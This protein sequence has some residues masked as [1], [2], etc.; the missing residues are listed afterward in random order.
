[1]PTN[2]RLYSF[3]PFT[4]D[5]SAR[6]LSIKDRPVALG[7]RSFEILVALLERRG[8]V[9]SKQDLLA[10]AWPGVH[11]EEHNLKVH[12]STLRRA[13]GEDGQGLLINIPGRGYSFVGTVEQHERAPRT[14]D[15]EFEGGVAAGEPPSVSEARVQIAPTVRIGIIHSLTG[16]MAQSEGPISE[17]T[18]L[19][20]E[21]INQAGGVLGRPIEPLVVDCESDE[22]CFSARAEE[23][24]TRE[25][26]SALFGCLT[27][28][29][30][31]QVKTVVERHD[32]LLIYP[33]QYEG[34]EQ[35]PNIFYLGAAPNQQLLPAAQWTFAF[36]RRRR[37]FLI[38]WDSIYSRASNAIL[39]DEIGALGGTVVGEEYIHVAGIEI[40]S[41][42]QKIA[43]ADADIILNSVVGDLNAPFCRALRGKGI[44]APDVP[45]VY[46][47]ISE[48]ELRGIPRSDAIGDY[49]VFSYFQSVDRPENRAFVAAFK[50]RYGN[51]RVTSD[52]M[53]SSYFG[54]YLWAQATKEAGGS[55]DISA[56]RQALRGQSFNA[57]G[58]RVT[59]D[60]ENQHTWKTVRI[61]EITNGGD[62]SVVWSS[63]KPIRPQ[64]YPASRS[65]AEWNEF[66][67]SAFGHWKGHWSRPSPL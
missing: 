45:M 46:L 10:R 22:T 63:E 34:L 12:V 1:M 39:R 7:S 33:M 55:S 14:A 15:G 35:S 64:P 65:V 56:V 9:V 30:R 37:F 48:N 49:G 58:G 29:S 18:L 60:R 31:K 8:D 23:L 57:P 50:N 16:P 38:G 61:A 3:G 5:V 19:A 40:G 2:H 43:E 26:I 66:I 13:M 54:V 21:E 6:R 11:V 4:L 27:S 47:S 17:A 25:G 67:E 44:R 51:H 52:P 24:I 42:V 28:A 20:I 32:H 62:F 59:I 53:E 41:V 36:L